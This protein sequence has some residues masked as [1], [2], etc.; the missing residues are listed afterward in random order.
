MLGQSIKA[1]R[2]FR[3]LKNARFSRIGILERRKESR[4]QTQL[5]DLGHL[6]LVLLDLLIE[7]AARNSQALGRFLNPPA[8]L[9]QDPFDVSLFQLQKR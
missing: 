5:L 7:R 1:L 9:H 6:D 2:E 3:C 4:I 8:L